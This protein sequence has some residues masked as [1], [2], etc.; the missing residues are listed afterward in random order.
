MP[1]EM[2]RWDR[3]LASLALSQGDRFI[4]QSPRE[5]ARLKAIMP[6]AQVRTCPLPV[7]D[8]NQQKRIHKNTALSQLG[9]SPT[10]PVL[11]CF[12]IVRA[13]KG[14]CY[15]IEAISELKKRGRRYHLLVAGEIW[16]DKRLYLNQIENLGIADQVTLDDR[17]IPNEEVSRYFSAADVFLA[18]YIDGTQ[19]A[20][21]KLALG[22]G[23][24]IVAS[25][26]LTDD[27]LPQPPRV[28]F[29]RPGNVNDL[30]SAIE[31]ASNLGVSVNSSTNF[32]ND[33]WSRLIKII[34]RMVSDPENLI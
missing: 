31:T 8:L 2:K 5:E 9:L 12:G 7:F 21:I 1:H 13:Y 28:L 26:I 4:V 30:S 20:A 15:A 18:P 10:G 17:Y 33:S 3:L 14:I 11:L 22:Y 27:M 6:A 29:V 24:P 34:E 19:S 32:I 25:D 23:L 16:E